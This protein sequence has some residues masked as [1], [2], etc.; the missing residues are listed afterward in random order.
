MKVSLAVN[1]SIGL[2]KLTG[3]K[4]NHCEIRTV[5]VT[6]MKEAKY[7]STHCSDG[8]LWW[9]VIDV[10]NGDQGSSRVGQTEVQVALH[11]GCLDYDGV[12]GHFLWRGCGQK[13]WLGKNE[14]K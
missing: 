8:Q 4:P 3:M 9:V 14:N 7:Q 12:L 11:V 1:L 6:S 5:C 2:G 13:T 10:C